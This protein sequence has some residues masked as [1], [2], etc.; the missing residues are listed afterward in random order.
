MFLGAVAVMALKDIF[1]SKLQPFL[2]KFPFLVLQE[3]VRWKI[4]TPACCMYVTRSKGADLG[5]AALLRVPQ[6]M[7]TV[8]HKKNIFPR[9]LF[10]EVIT[11][12]QMC[13]QRSLQ[14]RN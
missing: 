2:Q 9:V 4:Q 11:S 12:K 8:P 7:L 14:L 13:A 5:I 3:N 10:F 6:R 1:L